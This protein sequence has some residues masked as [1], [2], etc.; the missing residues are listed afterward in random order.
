M[1][2]ILSTGGEDGFVPGALEIW[3][4]KKNDAS[5]DYHDNVNADVFIAWF[6][7]LLQILTA[8]GHSYMIVSNAFGTVH[9]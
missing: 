3:P 1:Y 9:E 4:V 7:K 5:G 6:K 2:L 8:T